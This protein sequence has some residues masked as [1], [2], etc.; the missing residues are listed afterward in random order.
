MSNKRRLY[1]GT[2]LENLS[3]IQ[4]EGRVRGMLTTFKT[5]SGYGALYWAKLRAFEHK[6]IPVVLRLVVPKSVIKTKTMSC[7]YVAKIGRMIRTSY[8]NAVWVFEGGI[9]GWRQY[10][11]ID[12]AR[13]RRRGRTVSM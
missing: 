2:T 3:R 4:R 5:K 9:R 7:Y 10:K 11:S 13:N 6:K 8:V 1:H 12:A